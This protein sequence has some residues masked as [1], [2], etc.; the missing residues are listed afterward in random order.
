QIIL[1]PFLDSRQG[2]GFVL[3][4]AEH[5]DRDRGRRL[6][7]GAEGVQTA[8]V[9]KLQV[10][11]HGV[12]LAVREALQRVRKPLDVRD[13]KF[14]LA[15]VAQELV[16]EQGVVRAVF[17]EQQMNHLAVHRWPCRSL[18]RTLHYLCGQLWRKSATGSNRNSNDAV[19]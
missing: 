15:G 18:N 5:N 17:D 9:G 4:S 19:S 6:L 12:C 1:S 16:N 7:H 8:A 14:R 2:R 3:K 11:E 13:L 10:E